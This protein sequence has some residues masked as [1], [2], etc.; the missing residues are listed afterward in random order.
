[1][2]KTVVMVAVMGAGL[3]TGSHDNLSGSGIR[4]HVEEMALGVSGT[5]EPM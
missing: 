2:L 5:T 4:A 1:M 3:W